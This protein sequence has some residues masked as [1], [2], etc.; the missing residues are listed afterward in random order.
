MTAVAEGGY[1][2]T[3]DRELTVVTD[4]GV[5]L[6]V[7][8]DEGAP[9]A[10]AARPRKAPPRPTVVFSHGYTLN[11][12]SWVLQRR[13]L[14]RA[15]YRVVLWDQRSHGR[16]AVSPLGACTVE[17]IGADLAAVIEQVCPEGPLVL[18]GH[19]MGGMTMMSLAGR[20][21]ALVRSRVLAAAF[22]ATSAGGGG[23][24]SL[25]FGPLLGRAIGWAG[26][27]VLT[28]LGRHQ[29]WLDRFRR[30]GRDVE[31]VV[32][33]RYSFDSAVSEELVRFVGDMIFS[34]PLDV[35]AAFMPH[36][37]ALDQ[38]AHLD[39]FQ[40][41]EILVMNGEGDMLT[42]PSHSEDIVRHIP[43]AEHVV[44]EHAGHLI[45][46]EHPQLVTQQLLMLIERAERAHAEGISMGRKPRVRRMISELTPRGRAAKARSAS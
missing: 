36:I 19:S 34:T 15:G 35:M 16:S 10:G 25:G 42:P 32:V 26:P 27:G 12:S 28:R 18:I 9:E 29:A 44:V 23:M 37:D 38:V 39:A 13:A 3:A 1:A 14:A 43:G 33:S 21:P 45:M 30:L 6:H 5:A 4:D 46:L 40:G 31:E 17:R 20:D 7:E 8:V 41:I 22:I 2:H 24:T 11:L